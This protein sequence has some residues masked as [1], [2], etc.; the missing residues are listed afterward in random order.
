MPSYGK[1]ARAGTFWAYVRQAIVVTLAIPTA[2]MLARLLTPEDFGIAAAAGFFAQLSGRLTRAGLNLAI[3][4]M[5]ELEPIHVS[6]V[7]VFN[8][9]TSLVIFAIMSAAASPIGA[10][11]G[12]ASLAAVI[13]IASLNFVLNACGAVPMALLRRDMRFK[14]VMSI[15]TTGVVTEALTA[16]TLAFL[17]FGFWSIIYGVVASNI[18]SNASAIWAAR[19]K[20]SLRW[21]RRAYGELFSFGAGTYASRLLEYGALNIDNLVVGKLLGVTALG[22][23]DKAFST[24]NRALGRLNSAGPGVSFRIF[25]VIQEDIVRFRRGYRKVVLGVTMLVYPLFGFMAASAP[26]LIP[27]LF[28]P[29]WEPSVRPFQ[30]LCV[31]AMFKALNEYVG[32]ASQALG[33]VWSEVWRQLLYLGCIMTGIWL[34]R[35]FGVTGAAVA[36]LIATVLMFLLMQSLLASIAPVRW[37]DMLEPQLPGVLAAA[38]MVG[39]CTV[40]R[41]AILSYAP[42]AAPVTVL[43]AQAVSCGC[44]YLAFIFFSRFD[45]L[46]R[47]LKETLDDYAPWLGARIRLRA[48]TAREGAAIS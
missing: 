42:G 33:K 40:V 4:R 14:R 2:M 9:S 47:L 18:T 20:P 34:L 36:V 26:Q 19:W 41:A 23:Y 28:G 8:L 48:E 10:F 45:D 31:A 38:G 6:S 5:K 17:G 37:R 15:Q 12:N 25:A 16:V 46:R 39:V 3:I 11:F 1:L 24:M 13:P 30:V 27:V 21:S 43:T 22:Y 7:F 44:F 29:Q 32:S 35:G